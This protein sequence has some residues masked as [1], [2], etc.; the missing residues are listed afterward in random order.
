M[1]PGFRSSGRRSDLATRCLR[2]VRPAAFDRLEAAVDHGINATRRN[3]IASGL[4]APV[5]GKGRIAGETPLSLCM[6]PG[7]SYGGVMRDVGHSPGWTGDV[8][9]PEKRS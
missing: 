5:H 8:D 1:L 4:P 2:R 9:R 7:L 3:P 6:V